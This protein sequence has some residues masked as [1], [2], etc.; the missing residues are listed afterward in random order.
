[1]K[2]RGSI[3]APIPK[4][5]L[6]EYRKQKAEKRAQ[7]NDTSSRVLAGGP[8]AGVILRPELSV[9]YEVPQQEGDE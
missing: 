2:M 7:K 5:N 3:P 9:A 6:E 8:E 4:V 1:M